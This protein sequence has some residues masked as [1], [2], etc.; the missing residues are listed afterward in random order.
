[1]AR[2]QSREDRAGGRL[3]RSRRR[4]GRAPNDG[5]PTRVGGDAASAAPAPADFAAGAKRLAVVR[6]LAPLSPHHF[7][8][9]RRPSGR[10]CSGGTSCTRSAC[11]SRPRGPGAARGSCGRG[12]RP[13]PCSRASACG[14]RRS[15]APGESRPCGSGASACRTSPAAW[16]RRADP[17][18]RSR[19]PCRSCGSWQSVQVTPAAYIL[20]WRNEPYS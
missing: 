6:L 17:V 5:G 20:L 19:R 15:C 1:M 2:P 12:A 13:R 11:R 7:S 9:A 3:P 16:Q 4:Q 10:T 8:A 18:R 14:R